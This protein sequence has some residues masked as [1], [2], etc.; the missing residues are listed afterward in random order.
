[1]ATKRYTKKTIEGVLEHFKELGLAVYGP[2]M[3]DNLELPALMDYDAND[4]I[5]RRKCIENDTLEVSDD[6]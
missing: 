2:V 1:M 3:Q 4:I 6:W 5:N